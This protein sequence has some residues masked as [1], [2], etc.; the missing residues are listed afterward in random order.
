MAGRRV[1]IGA[2]IVLGVPTAAA[3]LFTERFAP[4]DDV[5]RFPERVPGAAPPRWPAEEVA[6]LRWLKQRILDECPEGQF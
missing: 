2:A 4:A 6:E 3:W 5:R 1:V